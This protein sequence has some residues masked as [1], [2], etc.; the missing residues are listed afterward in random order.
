MTTHVLQ[1][2]SEL[3]NGGAE[4][5]MMDVYRCIDSRT[6]VFDFAVVHGGNH[7]FDSE[8]LEK[9][10]KKYL[11]PDPRKG[12]VKNYIELVRFFKEHQEFQAVHAHVAW[13]NGVVLMAARQAGVK[14]RIAHARDSVIPNRTFKQKLIS[15]IGK[16]LIQISATQKIAISTE[17]AENIFGKRVV[18]NKDFLFVPN[19]IDQKKYVVLEGEDR[20]KLRGQLGIPSEKKAYVTVANLRKQ[21]NH[22]FLLDI[23]VALKDINDDFILYLIGEGDLRSEI[24]E[25]I[26][27]LNIEKNVVLMG[28]R[29]DVPNILCAFDGMIFPSLFEGLGGVV[30]EAQLVGV[31][32][33]V[34]EGIPRIVDVGIDMVDYISLSAAP[35]IWANKIV[36]KFEKFSWDREN[37]LRAFREHGY[38]IEETAKRYLQEYEIDEQT[39]D[40]ALK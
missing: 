6:V 17:A 8:I 38:C 35:E 22:T 30:L 5:R 39:I 25:K 27:F 26:K 7:F 29:K 33:V 11:L 36:D 20:T 10:S 40:Q 12:L 37:T 1:F 21:K 18:Q 16:F 31:P 14:I 23:V 19:S 24:E 2:F 34:S 28:S 15:D 4:N 32:C 9:G 13:Y 3:G